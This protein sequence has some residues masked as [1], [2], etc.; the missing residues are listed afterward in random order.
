MPRHDMPNCA[1]LAS[2]RPDSARLAG[3]DPAHLNPAH[4]NPVGLLLVCVLLACLLLVGG[5]AGPAP[6]AGK[7]GQD[8]IDQVFAALI[9]SLAHDLAHD[10]ATDLAHDQRDHHPGADISIE[11]LM[12][13]YNQSYMARQQQYLLDMM[14]RPQSPVMPPFMPQFMPAGP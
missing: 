6:I 1:R 12:D 9:E 8:E 11:M 13:V 10:R 5:C 3:V 2:T 4:L 14:S 7:M